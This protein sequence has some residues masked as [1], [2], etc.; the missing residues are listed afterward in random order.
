MDTINQA[1]G[2]VIIPAFSMQ[3]TQE[4]AI[5]LLETMEYNL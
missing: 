1:E 3:R 5:L 4:I 2:K